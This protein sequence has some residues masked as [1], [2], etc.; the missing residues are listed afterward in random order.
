[1]H[2]VVADLRG[3]GLF[4][5][6]AVGVLHLDDDLVIAAVELQLQYPCDRI[7]I[8][9]VMLGQR[10]SESFARR[11]AAGR[12][13]RGRRR[14]RR[15]NAIHAYCGDPFG[16]GRLAAND[17]ARLDRNRRALR[18]RDAC[19]GIAGFGRAAATTAAAPAAAPATRRRRRCWR[20]VRRAAFSTATA[21]GEKQAKS[22]AQEYL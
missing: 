7:L 16:I 10:R 20:R 4:G 14:D 18:K 5:N 19:R 9:Q 2:L 12:G 11:D 22:K 6:A 21:R 1:G 8:R 3:I 17:D 13:S 15:R